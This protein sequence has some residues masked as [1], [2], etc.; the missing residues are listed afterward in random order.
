MKKQLAAWTLS[1]FILLNISPLFSAEIPNPKEK[2]AEAELRWL[3]AEAY[4]IEVVTASRKIQKISEAPAS[5]ISISQ[6]QIEA[7][8][9]RYLKDIFRA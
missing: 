8:G 6:D 4:D 9:C 5:I 7:Y 2:K 3:R 1:F